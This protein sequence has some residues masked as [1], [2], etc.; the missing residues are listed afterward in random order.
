MANDNTT[1]QAVIYNGPQDWHAWSDAIKAKATQALLW[2][3]FQGTPWPSEPRY[4]E[5]KDYEAVATS[6][7]TSGG[8]SSTIRP[9][10][11]VADASQASSATEDDLN[12]RIQALPP[13]P[14]GGITDRNNSDYPGIYGAALQAR[15]RRDAALREYAAQRASIALTTIRNAETELTARGEKQYQLAVQR[16]THEKREFDKTHK[17]ASALLDWTYKS[18]K[19][20]YHHLF[21]EKRL[22]ER[23]E[24]LENFSAP[25]TE[26]I[27]QDT[28]ETYYNHLN[29]IKKHEKKMGQWIATWMDNM[30]A[31]IRYDLDDIITPTTWC[32]LLANALRN[33]PEGRQ[34]VLGEF[35]ILEDSIKSG[36]MDYI[37]VAAKMQSRLR[38]SERPGDKRRFDGAFPTYGSEEEEKKEESEQEVDRRTRTQPRGGRGQG[39]GG[40]NRGQGNGANDRGRGRSTRGNKSQRS[41]MAPSCELCHRKGHE[42]TRCF[43]TYPDKHADLPQWWSADHN[44]EEAGFVNDYLKYNESLAKK[45]KQLKESRVMA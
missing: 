13:P 27:T 43:Y 29:A 41:R 8:S 17:E 45:V 24:A 23:Y 18:V 32:P 44:P 5:P 33:I 28:R 7:N 11:G 37:A 21:R 31:A 35:A 19:V 9:P 20:N 12:E 4:P 42:L 30:A 2:T 40:S 1:T 16:Y 6:G 3:Y 10:R 39:R 34:W 14:A 38:L 25:F 26:R 15:R 36:Q 22:V